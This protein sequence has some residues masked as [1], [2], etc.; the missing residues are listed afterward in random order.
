MDL[1]LGYGEEEGKGE[2]GEENIY[3]YIFPFLSTV[4]SNLKF[5]LY[6]SFL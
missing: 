3:I 2:R 1:C 6:F 4:N 5:Y